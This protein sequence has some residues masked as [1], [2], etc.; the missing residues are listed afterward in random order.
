MIKNYKDE[1]ED[2]ILEHGFAALNHTFS[3]LIIENDEK[4]QLLMEKA[5]SNKGFI[6]NLFQYAYYGIEVNH[7]KAPDFEKSKIELKVAG[8]RKNANGSL[9][10]D[11]RLVLS[12]IDFSD[13]IG[14]I[15]LEES[16]L[17]DKCERMLMFY[18]LLDDSIEDRLNCVVNYM[19]DYKMFIIP[20][21]DLKIIQ[22]DY[23]KIVDKIRSG[24]ACEI[25]E[26]DT[27]ILSACRRDGGEVSY[28]I[29]G[30]EYKALPRRFAFK[31][32]YITY[33]LNE[34]IEPGRPCNAP[35]KKKS[36][37]RDINIRS[38]KSF[39]QYV[40]KEISKY[41]N[42]TALN[43]SK[44]KV[45]NYVGFASAKD[46]TKYSRLAF[47]MLG[48]DS[49]SAPYLQKTAT[50]IKAIRISK[51][52]HIDQSVSFPS[53][54]FKEMVEETEWIESKTY[55]YLSE[56]RFLFIVF[57]ENNKGEYELKGY[58]FYY[59]SAE[60]LDEYF[61]PV[62]EKTIDLLKKGFDFEQEKVKGKTTYKNP[63]PGL[64][65]NGIC[66]I[67]PH[68]TKSAYK[69][70]DGTCVGE[71]KKDANEMPDGQW[72]TTQSFWI[73]N[74]YVMEILKEFMK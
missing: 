49:N 53:F 57:K 55:D 42:R 10:A 19:F 24:K 38:G 31:N 45:V 26:A 68:S 21:E 12:S 66:H 4:V 74:K 9:S 25:S 1:S 39:E 30:K 62:W 46:D 54:K 7:D 33:L 44:R 35:K 43:I 32:A 64:A 11:Q 29:E 16:P 40:E 18:F 70:K 41:I 20:K 72:M 58:K 14:G 47:K 23:F 17:K 34:Y 59:V 65:D 60:L 37:I 51:N 8:Y 22:A 28:N 56:R 13:Y 63:L 52:N 5:K 69:F 48:V 67:R 3:D 50:T 36:K 73:N 71:W 61:K 15:K 2:K 6:G 27:S